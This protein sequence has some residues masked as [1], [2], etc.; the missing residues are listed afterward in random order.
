MSELEWE[1]GEDETHEYYETGA[2][3]GRDSSAYACVWRN[4]PG[5]VWMVAVGN[6]EGGVEMLWDKLENDRQRKEEG[7]PESEPVHRLRRQTPLC[8]KDPHA[9]FAPA[10][11]AL[12]TGEREFRML[13]GLG[14]SAL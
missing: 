10:E 9:L 12:A 11:D 13:R 4:K 5:D 3:K 7:L 1:H 14:R 6:S 8:S 2:W